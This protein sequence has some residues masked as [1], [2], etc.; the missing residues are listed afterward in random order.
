MNELEQL[1]ARLRLIDEKI[2]RLVAERQA[3]VLQAAELK[4]ANGLPVRFPE[5]ELAT[6][7]RNRQRARELG[8]PEDTV[9]AI[10]RALI[11]A[12]VASQLAHLRERA[13][14]PA[15]R[16]IAQR[17][18]RVLPPSPGMKMGSEGE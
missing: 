12:S 4:A 13:E 16:K 11:E 18:S 7:A 5:V 14:G 1:R 3:L 15:G 6:I 17:C 10:T 9:E 8:A 2:V